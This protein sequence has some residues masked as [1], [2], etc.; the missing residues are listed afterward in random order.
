MLNKSKLGY[1]IGFIAVLGLGFAMG[2]TMPQSFAQKKDA[3]PYKR[4]DVF[5]Q[6][7]SVVERN[8]VEPTDR[9]A[10]IDGAI[11]GMIRALDPH[12]SYMSAEERAEFERRTDGKFVG[13][14]VEIGLRNDELR[15]ITAFY[16]GPAQKAGIESGDTILAIDN[17]DVSTMSLDDLFAALRGTPGSTVKL[18]VRRPDKLAL[19]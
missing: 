2:A 3:D 11:H 13:I 8:Y 17:K 5:A 4:L 19:K 18:T 7:L 10:M 6:V 1:G 9:T 12:S 14:G 15:V 16:G